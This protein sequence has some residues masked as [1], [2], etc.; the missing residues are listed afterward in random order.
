MKKKLLLVIIATLPALMLLSC[1]KEDVILADPNGGSK[2]TDPNSGG[3][4]AK[5]CYVSEMKFTED[6]VVKITKFNYNSKNLLES[7]EESDGKT[8]FEYDAN[9]RITKMNLY[10][11]GIENFTYEYDSKGN[12]SKIKY[13]AE[14]AEIVVGISEY[15]L[16]TNAKGQVDKI[17]AISTEDEETFDLFLEY[18]AN[19]NI[20][21]LILDDGEEKL[22]LIQNFKFDN[23]SNIFLNTNLSKAHIP[24]VIL[25]AFFGVNTT[26]LF[27]ANNVLSDSAFSFFT[28]EEIT[29]TYDYGYTTEGFPSR[30]TA[31]RKT[32]GETEK[33][34]QTF[35][36]TCK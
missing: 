19:N 4:N 16:S 28:N 25:G 23:K 18:D 24:H 21:K 29:T 36:Y 14:G 8:T 7:R 9:N 34:E 17:K 6:G 31:S 26:S 11:K 2:P 1:G 20:T 5:K 12:M 22:T 13:Y 35:T 27:N 33:E 30:M 15:I 10:S 3:N 32:G